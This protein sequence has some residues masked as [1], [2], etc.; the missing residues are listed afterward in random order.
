MRNTIPRAAP[1]ERSCF[2][3]IGGQQVGPEVLDTV[4]DGREGS[5]NP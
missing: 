4:G 3:G 5:L 2:S 1:F